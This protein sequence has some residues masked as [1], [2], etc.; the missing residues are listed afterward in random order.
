MSNALRNTI[1]KNLK[2]YNVGDSYVMNEQQ[3]EV[4]AVKISQHKQ[5]V[6]GA[7]HVLALRQ[8]SNVIEYEVSPQKKRQRKLKKTNDVL[9]NKSK[10]SIEKENDRFL[11]IGFDTEWHYVNDKVKVLSMQFSVRHENNL[12]HV[13]FYFEEHPDI[14]MHTA[15]TILFNT[16]GFHNIDG[17]N[18]NLVA[19]YNNADLSKFRDCI[20]IYKQLT[21]VRKSVVTGSRPLPMSWY[22]QKA[23]KSLNVKIHIRDTMLITPG[24]SSLERVGSSIGI[25]KIQI[26]K[27]L[28]E[29]MDKLLI[30]N[31]KLFTDY[32]INDS[33]IVLD[34]VTKLF[35]G[36][37]NQRL[38]ITL[39]GEACKAA[40]MY[41]RK[42]NKYN[43]NKKY[44]EM[45][46]GKSTR[47]ETVQITKKDG[48]HM[49]V[50]QYIYE[51]NDNA[52]YMNTLAIRSYHGGRN[53]CFSNGLILEKTYDMDLSGAYSVAMSLTPDIDYTQQPKDFTNVELTEK[54]IGVGEVGFGLIEFKFPDD[55]K[56]PCLPVKDSN[57]G[58]LIYPLRGKTNVTAPEIKLALQMGA[59]IHALRFIMPAVYEEK[60]SLRHVVQYFTNLRTDAA[61]RFGKKSVEALKFK[62]MLNSIYGKLAQGLRKKRT[63]NLESNQSEDVDVSKLTNPI[64]ACH[65]TGV[66]R[67]LVSGAIA[68]LDAKGF[69]THSVTTDGFI[70]TAN[71]EIM[72]NLEIYGL[73]QYFLAGRKIATLDDSLE[74]F[75]EEKHSQNILLNI[76][77]RGNLGFTDN[78]DNGST[79]VEAKNG[80]KLGYEQ[81][82]KDLA[83]EYL[84][85]T[86]TIA[87]Q[88]L[89][90]DSIKDIVRGKEQTRGTICTKRLDFDPDYKRELIN[91]VMSTIFIDGQSYSHVTVS[92][93]PHRSLEDYNTFRKIKRAQSKGLT[94]VQDINHINTIKTIRDLGIK[95]TDTVYLRSLLSHIA[96]G[97]I[98]HPLLDNHA[99]S[100]EILH[101]IISVG[102]D[103]SQEKLN[104]LLSNCQMKSRQEKLINPELLLD[105]KFI[106]AANDAYGGFTIAKPA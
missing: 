98:N 60:Y 17:Y 39:G 61:E 48:T 19:H 1:V 32:A 3:C 22:S 65:I 54:D 96:L 71:K 45:F 68:E 34:Y 63:Y 12:Y 75:W 97:N 13:I 103:I 86:G 27:N 101:K 66:V 24:G 78:L 50:N 83:M 105:T 58:G 102:Y 91:P 21:K 69:D 42:V 80:Y 29:N 64:M 82:K 47:R 7:F 15:F 49:L 35:N 16:L 73:G 44:Y 26:E 94:T 99:I 74:T 88:Y 53:E 2:Q 95:M 59:K 87:N 100:K 33:A 85:R 18:I 57:G 93:K 90:L 84:T 14:T 72:D 77:T 92:S 46:L 76:K 11:S 104:K 41:I 30:S 4:V 25:E 9:E 81:T 79:G 89:K 10:N 51:D 70:T 8:I 28:K 23:K 55:T 106:K 38:F 31:F 5:K 43:T 62:E 67:A 6:Q 52:A 36:T 40:Q 20:D 56:F 37:P